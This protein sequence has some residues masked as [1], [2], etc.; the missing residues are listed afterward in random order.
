MK[1]LILLAFLFNFRNSFSQ[2]QSEDPLKAE[3]D[4]I[5]KQKQDN[6]RWKKTNDDELRDY[7]SKLDAN[8]ASIAAIDDQVKNYQTNLNNV[9]NEADNALSHL[10]TLNLISRKAAFYKCI[11]ASINDQGFLDVD[12]CRFLHPAKFNSDEEAVIEKWNRLVGKSLKEL[13]INKSF[14]QNEL[15]NINFHLDYRL[16]VGK[17]IE[18]SEA[19]IKSKEHNLKSKEHNLKSKEYDFKVAKDNSKFT[20]CDENSPAISLEEEV[21]FPGATFKGPFF[22]VPRDNQD[23]IGSCF[24]NTAKNLLLSGTDGGDVASF[25]DLALLYQNKNNY[26]LSRGLDGGSS[27]IVIN[28][29]NQYGYCPQKYAPSELGEKNPYTQSLTTI[30]ASVNDDALAVNLVRNFLVGQYTLNKDKNPFSQ[31]ALTK[32]KYI[33]EAIKTRPN[34]HLP[35]PI[36]NHDVPNNYKIQEAYYWDSAVKATGSF[37]QFMGEYNKNYKEKFYPKYVKA[38]LEGKNADEIF[39]IYTDAMK[40]VIDKY[41]LS[42]HLDVWKKLYTDETAAEFND[43][44]LK[45]SIMESNDFI[46]GIVNKSDDKSGNFI[47]TCA[48]QLANVLDYIAGIKPLVEYFQKNNINTNNIY[49]D[50]GEFRSPAELMQLIVAPECL[51]SNKR[52][53]PKSP[54]ICTAND[55]FVAGIKNSKKDENEKKRIIREKIVTS[56]VQ[57]YA[58]GRTT[59]TGTHINTIVGM[60]FDANTHSC[61]YQVRESQ[62]GTTEWHSEDKVYNDMKDLT[63]VRKDQ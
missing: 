7:Q 21:P 9:S 44:D 62:T 46:K 33:I 12:Y 45:K 10:S 3:R 24:A 61:Q 29:V 19:N 25:L 48:S 40:N 50:K 41:H 22:E 32:S 14:L 51:D 17:N 37:E 28:L 43:P 6:N 60:R 30:N 39:S 47:S 26:I 2:S 18:A 27:C 53:K 52:K 57:G 63:I 56:L 38:V 8:T 4:A 59:G 15:K 13:S 16:K 1:T 35:L 5:E 55:G 42:S 31:A 58:V 49:N 36:V 54:L 34:L 11:K 23:G 20:K